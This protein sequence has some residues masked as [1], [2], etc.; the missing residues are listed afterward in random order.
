MHA[1]VAGEGLLP[2][3]LQALLGKEADRPPHTWAARLCHVVAA[4]HACPAYKTHENVRSEPLKYGGRRRRCKHAR[5]SAHLRATVRICAQLRAR[6]LANVGVQ[7]KAII[8]RGRIVA[9]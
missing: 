9:E 3:G 8:S 1:S 5:L 6:I 7:R 2:I 4:A